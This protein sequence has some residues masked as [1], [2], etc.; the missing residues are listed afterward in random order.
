[1]TKLC[2]V[3]IA[4]MYN[5]LSV[6]IQFCVSIILSHLTTQWNLSGSPKNCDPYGGHTYGRGVHH[7]HFT[8]SCAQQIVSNC[9][10]M[11]TE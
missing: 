9:L 1:M 2:S 7:I 5:Y 4:T 3:Y 10:N 11:E 8:P 6:D